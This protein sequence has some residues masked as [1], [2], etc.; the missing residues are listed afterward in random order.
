MSLQ[1]DGISVNLFLARTDEGA[2]I[3]SEGRA[4]FAQDSD[5]APRRA[6]RG[7]SEVARDVT[8]PTPATVARILVEVGGRVTK[9]QP[10][11]VVSAMKM[12][13]TLAAPYSGRV[14][15]VNTEVGAQVSPG[16]ILVEIDPEPEAESDE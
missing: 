9:G 5:K 1:V 14:R 4:R 3:W 10:V 12:E 15:S 16:D 13:M 2:W 6:S 7:P 11:I 8:P